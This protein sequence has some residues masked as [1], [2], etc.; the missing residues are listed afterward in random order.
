MLNFSSSSRTSNIFSLKIL[1]SFI[2]KF[3]SRSFLSIKKTYF[4]SAILSE[5]FLRT[6]DWDCIFS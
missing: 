6:I 2:A 3:N 5:A 1:F 4:Y